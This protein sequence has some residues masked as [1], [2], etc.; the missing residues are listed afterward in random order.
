MA[1]S[2]RPTVNSLTF[3]PP[4][5]HEKNGGAGLCARLGLEFMVRRTH[6]TADFS[7]PQKTENGKQSRMG[8][9]PTREA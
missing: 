9:C 4:E 7:V 1:G 6:P 3:G 8:H 5:K 2:A